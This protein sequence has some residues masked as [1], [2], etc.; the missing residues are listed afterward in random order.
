MSI[1]LT[2]G[3]TYDA[4]R[5]K[6]RTMTR[7]DVYELVST[8]G[9]KA[10]SGQG[11][12]GYATEVVGAESSNVTNARSANPDG[13]TNVGLF[14]IDSKN[15]DVPASYLEDPVYNANVAR[16]MFIAD[17]L[18]FSKHWDARTITKANSAAKLSGP[19]DEAVNAGLPDSV[20]G[21]T[22]L[23][24]QLLGD[25]MSP[26]TWFRI[27]KGALGFVLIVAGTFAIVFT[28]ASKASPAKAAIKS[29]T[30]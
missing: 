26:D 4:N 22:G 2:A 7:S 20:S 5:A 30:G 29:V 19:E 6:P 9:W 14:Q 23:L 18:T 3:L 27:G 12:A 13:G 11:S 28:V 10:Q 1:A 15:V 21:W 8:A 24:G 17:G 16:R 25:I